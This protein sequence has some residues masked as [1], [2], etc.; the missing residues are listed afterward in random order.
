M[1]VYPFKL[2]SESNYYIVM[3]YCYHSTLG[4]LLE[5]RRRRRTQF[6]L[7]E[8]MVVMQNLLAGYGLL[9]SKNMIHNDLKPQNIFVKD[10]IFKIGDFGIST[11]LNWHDKTFFPTHCSLLYSPIEKIL[12]KPINH[13]ADIYSLGLIFAEIMFGQHP[14]YD[15]QSWK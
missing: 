10:K 4:E 11:K 1:K 7:G 15:P 3:E 2:V 9:K 6:N 13:K 8:L 5:N 14:Y 12:R